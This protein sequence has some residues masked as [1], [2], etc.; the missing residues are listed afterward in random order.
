MKKYS[1]LVLLTTSIFYLTSSFAEVNVRGYYRADGTYVHPYTRSDP[2]RKGEK[3]VTSKEA[4]KKQL[5]TQDLSKSK[6][7]KNKNKNLAEKIK[8]KMKAKAKKDA[9]TKELSTMGTKTKIS[10][11]KTKKIKNDKT[12]AAKLS[13]A[14]KSKKSANTAAETLKTS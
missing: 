7:N 4:T 10:T 3:K 11:K 13:K 6:T 5:R 12:K 8:A 9:K 14:K 1:I 2:H